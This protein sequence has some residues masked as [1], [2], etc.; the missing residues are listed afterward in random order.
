MLTA[1]SKSYALILPAAVPLTG[2]ELFFPFAK[3]SVRIHEDYCSIDDAIRF[4]KPCR[5][6]TV[7]DSQE[8]L[9]AG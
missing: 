8:T 1:H 3:P 9:C 2:K 7:K 4:C 5:I 6:K